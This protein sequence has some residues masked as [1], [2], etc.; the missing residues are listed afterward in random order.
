MEEKLQRLRVA[1]KNLRQRLKIANSEEMSNNKRSKVSKQ[2]VL[3]YLKT[4]D[5]NTKQI[6]LFDY[7]AWLSK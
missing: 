2:T 6:S 1:N 5:K 4:Q 7:R 3:D